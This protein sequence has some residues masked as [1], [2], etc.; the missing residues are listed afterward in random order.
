[1]EINLRESS[2]WTATTVHVRDGKTL[3]TDGPFVETKE[4]LGSIYVIKARD[5]NDAIQVAKIPSAR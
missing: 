1:L 4:Q 5:L 3:T 2:F